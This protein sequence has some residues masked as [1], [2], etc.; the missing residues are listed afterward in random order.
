MASAALKVSA[1][2]YTILSRHA[3]LARRVTLLKW[4][5]RSHRDGEAV[6]YA[7]RQGKTLLRWPMRIGHHPTIITVIIDA[8]ENLEF[9]LR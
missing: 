8:M 1:C 6:Q 7:M 9:T 5:M 2:P 4:E 3:S